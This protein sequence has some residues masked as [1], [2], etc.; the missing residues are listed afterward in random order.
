M[1]IIVDTSKRILRIGGREYACA[2]G[3]NGVVPECDGREGDGKTPLGTYQIRYGMYRA[4]KVALPTTKL[5]FW[6][7][8]RFD[9]WCDAPDDLAY[10][11]PVRLPY[12]ASTETLWRDS[13]VY[14]IILVLGHND[15]PP[16]AGMGSAVFLHVAREG[17][18]PTEGC[19]AVSQV[20]M[21]ALIPKLSPDICVEI[22]A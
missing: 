15:N 21:L 11:R 18:A 8:R 16:K 14:D 3:K 13:G 22:L 7:I 6:P 19:V 17:Y 5:L 4:N 10:N 20:D 1:K 2:I 12:P 9:G